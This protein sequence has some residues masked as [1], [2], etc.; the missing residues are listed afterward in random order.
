MAKTT[1][2]E[3]S[4]LEILDSRGNPTIR[5]RVRLESGAE[6][7]ASVP[8]GASTGKREALELRDGDDS[9]YLGKGVLK[10]VDNVRNIIAPAVLGMDGHAQQELDRKMMEL[11]GTLSKQN[12]GANAILSVS[13]GAAVAT[14]RGRERPHREYEIPPER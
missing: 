1:I 5:T 14:A 12:L 10:A 8:S 13:M 3:I 6:G 11:D 4:P 9:R 7:T 2:T